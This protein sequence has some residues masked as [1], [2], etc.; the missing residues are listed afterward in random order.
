MKNVFSLKLR[1]NS[2]YNSIAE[3]DKAEI[4]NRD[5]YS[6]SKINYMNR[7]GKVISIIEKHFEPSQSIKIADFGCAQGNIS[8]MLAEMDYK[9]FVVDIRKDFLD[10]AKL[11]YEKGNIEWICSNIEM[12]KFEEE[13][14]DVIVMGELVE[15]CAFPE[16]IIDKVFKFL[17]KNGL[18][19]L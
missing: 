15:H 5:D 19:I 14:F 16:R 3:F 18:L 2:L 6:L 9:V 11:K 12:C 10:Y 8:L 17:K 4:D 1:D 7:I 13:Y